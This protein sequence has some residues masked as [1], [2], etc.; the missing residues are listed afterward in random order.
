MVRVYTRVNIDRRP[1]SAY[2]LPQSRYKHNNYAVG[3]LNETH[4]DGK[5]PVGVVGLAERER[6]HASVCSPGWIVLNP[7]AA[8]PEP[9]PRST[10][11]AAGGS[12]GFPELP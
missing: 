7:S 1:Q 5:A 12:D 2:E 9:P 10:W 8:A 11:R 4:V 6:T 3:I